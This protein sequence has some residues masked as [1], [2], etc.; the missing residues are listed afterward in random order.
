MADVA[1]EAGVSAQ[2]VSRALR[3]PTSVSAQAYR[4]ITEAIQ[5]TRYIPNLAAS[6][7][8]AGRSN[9]VAAIIPL[10]SASVFAETVQGLNDVL[11]AEG[12]NLLLGHT[13]YRLGREEALVQLLSGRR[14]DGFFLIGTH[15]SQ[16]TRTLLRATQAPVV[17][18]WGWTERPID[19]LVGFSNRA[20]ME[21]MVGHLVGRG[22]RR[23]AVAGVLRPGDDR[24]RERL[25]GFREAVARLL[26]DEPL[27]QLAS[28]DRPASMATGAFLLETL[29]ERSPEI[30]VIAFTSDVFASGALLACQRRGLSVPGDM[31][32]AGFGDYEIAEQL[33]PALTTVA[34]PAR[35][36]GQVAAQL[37]LDTLQ[38]GTPARRSV[39]L[40]FTMRPRASA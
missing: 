22:Y 39:D 5:Q 32:I 4:R 18:S 2:T 12:Y 34:V 35:K 38:N 16:A 7:L 8:A 31:A 37:L 30:E 14:P 26:P 1:R 21:A 24:A 3:S 13:D 15:H 19:M 6:H 33:V 10:L 27:R 29:L 40:G 9:T 11:L 23:L 20:A 25:A 28:T 17:E 36:M